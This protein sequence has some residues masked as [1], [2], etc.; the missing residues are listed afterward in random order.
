MLARLD[1]HVFFTYDDD[2]SLER[3]VNE[4]EDLVRKA[5]AGHSAMYSVET[6]EVHRASIPEPSRE[7]AFRRLSQEVGG[8][9]REGVTPNFDV[10]V[11]GGGLAGLAAGATAALGGASTVVLE[12]HRPGGRA[13]TTE[14]KGFVFNHGTH[15]LYTGGPAMAVLDAL[16]VRPTGTP[17]PLNRY[18]VL[19]GGGQ[20]ILPSSP[21]TLL[22][23]TCLGA[24]DKAQFGKLFA[25]LPRVDPRTLAGQSVSG[26]LAG[27]NLRPKVDALARAFFRL[28]TYAADLDQLGADGA[29]AQLQLGTGPGVIYVD[30]GWSQLVD[31]LRAK[32]QVRGGVRV[33]AVESDR[34]GATV[35]T[36]DGTFTA[37]SVVLASGA[38][39]AV[40]SLLPGDPGWGDL[41]EPVT[42]AC[43]D[44][45][46]RRAPSPGYVLGMDEPLYG[47]TQSP[48]ARQAPEGC[49]VV[50]VIRYGARSAEDDRPQ[51]EGHLREVGVDDDDVVV[52]R[53]LARMVVTGAMPRAETGGLAGRPSVTATG[54][55]RVFLAGDWV[56]PDGL[57][58]DAALASGHAAVRSAL[59]TVE[60]STTLV[61]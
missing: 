16:H 35:H 1:L 61:A 40:R 54:L 33:R 37:R 7:G 44:V 15:A 34:Y 42:A 11:V 10:I 48:P 28:T 18:T 60:G 52:S 17:P 22:R 43:L 26:W 27:R 55:R 36:D 8:V 45:G 38:P 31:A 5:L 3:H 30:G 58:A 46:V 53:F 49:A 19:T 41:G 29:V 59:R 20:H 39:D 51:L 50:A 12:A 24:R 2:A 47:T 9:R 13:R 25:S 4:A 21:R 23:T 57:L 56:G 32:V 6:A 14:R